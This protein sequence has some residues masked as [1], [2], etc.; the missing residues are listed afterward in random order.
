MQRLDSVAT[1][2]LGQAPPGESYNTE[3]DG[4][5]LI[6]G[7]GDFKEGVAAP[8]KYTTKPSKL[9]CPG[10]IILGIRA[11]I[12]EKVIS[13]KEY[14]LGRGV[15]SLRPNE[16]INIRYLWNWL[17]FS[18][19]DLAAKGKGATFKQV[20]SKHIAEMMIPVP[21]LDEQRRIAEALD[22][23][24]ALRE[25]RQ[26]SITLLDDLTQSVYHEM[27][28]GST[29]PAPVRNV[30]DV[31][32]VVIDCV[33]KTAPT[34][35]YETD[36]KMIRTTNIK[37]GIVS[38]QSVRFVVESTFKAWTKRV[39]PIPDDVILTREAPVGE[40][41]I[42]KESDNLFLGQRLMLYRADPDYLTPEYLLA[43]L[44]SDA[45]RHQYWAGS[46][47]S[48][49]KHL[50]VAVCRNL[51]IPTPALSEQIEF[52]DRIRALRST[53]DSAQT[54]LHHLDTLLASIQ[55]RAFRSELWQDD[56]KD[57]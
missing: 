4:W 18:S 44:R 51:S 37:N 2:T 36:Y 29:A 22:Q 19:G 50:P 8:K 16:R 6:A 15:A 27:F 41:G 52:S 7:A 28:L 33:N 48:T 40:A 32:S 43:T 17:G 9:S 13:D 1:I 23:V 45:L 46:S 35:D 42:L 53:K 56:V 31:C 49:V 38:T 24:D 3:G 47:G 10:D 30:S 20:N 39:R 54:Q 12:G 26:K 55:S 11:S 21:S 14:C 5:P 57:L 25:K 34:V